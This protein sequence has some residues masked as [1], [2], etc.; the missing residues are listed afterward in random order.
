MSVSVD[1]LNGDQ[2]QGRRLC[3]CVFQR[4][5]HSIRSPVTISQNH[6]HLL[7][8]KQSLLDFQ[9]FGIFYH[10]SAMCINEEIYIRVLK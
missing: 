6:F 7:S 1:R 9:I 2:L 8:K 5:P 4:Q 3:Q 10:K